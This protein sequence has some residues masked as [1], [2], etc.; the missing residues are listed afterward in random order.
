MDKYEIIGGTPLNGT[1]TVSG[2]K[3]AAVAILPAAILVEGKCRVE[4]VPD[5]SDVRILLD[6]LRA[7]GAKISQ[8]ETGVVEL[9]CTDIHTVKPDPALVRRMRASYYLMGALMSRFG[10]AEVALPG[11]CNFAARPIDQHVKGFRALGAKV[12]ETP[13]CVYIEPGPRGLKGNRVSL[14]VVSVGATVNIIMA[15]TLLPGQTVIENAAKEPHIVDLANFLNTMGAHISG[16]GTGTIKVRGVES[17]HGG[18]YAIIPDQIEAGTYMAAVVAAGGNVLVKNVIPKHMECITSKL[19]EMGCQ[20]IHYDD[21]VRVSCNGRLRHTTVKTRPYPGFPTDM[22]AQICVCMSL[23][24]GVSRLTESVYETRFFGYCT[25]LQSM[26]ADIQINGKTAI[27]TGTDSISG[28]T[29]YAHDLRA[30]AALVIAG[31]AA[32]GVTYVENIHYVERGYENIIEKLTSLGARI[33][34]MEE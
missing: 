8:P 32:E 18:T 30:G 9:D 3:N 20:V 23:A 28:T 27:V 5:I 31:L 2:A 29:V 12:D 33:K 11:G 14:D 16:A 6:I 1:V 4:N 26:G 7:M 34:R 21:A 25:E 15:A 22:Q 13:D 10:Q 24:S 17:L 19:Q